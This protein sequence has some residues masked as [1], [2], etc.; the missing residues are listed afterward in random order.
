MWLGLMLFNAHHDAWEQGMSFEQ[1]KAP[2]KTIEKG[3]IYFHGKEI[4]PSLEH[5]LLPNR[6]ELSI[7][8]Y[9]CHVY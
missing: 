4:D 7:P 8:F 6:P 5:L 1:K 3:G 2:L 9:P